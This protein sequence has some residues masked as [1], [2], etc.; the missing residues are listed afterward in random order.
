MHAVPHRRELAQG[1]AGAAVDRLH[2]D[3]GASGRR[4]CRKSPSFPAGFGKCSAFYAGHS[5][6][7]Q[8]KPQ[9]STEPGCAVLS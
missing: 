8:P 1:G 9:R 7:R 6:N 3:I 4:A 5:R 2:G